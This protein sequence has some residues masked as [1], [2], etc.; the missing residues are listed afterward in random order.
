VHVD[1][2]RGRST[3]VRAGEPA[4][5]RT[6]AIR[7]TCP[8]YYPV[9]TSAGMLY[10]APGDP[11]SAVRYVN[12]GFAEVP[13]DPSLAPVPGCGE[14]FYP[15]PADFHT[16]VMRGWNGPR[17]L[18]EWDAARGR[19]G[20]SIP[21]AQDAHTSSARAAHPDGVIEVGWNESSGMTHSPSDRELRRYYR[22]WRFDGGEVSLLRYESGGWVRT[23][24]A[25]LAV[26]NVAGS[27]HD[28]YSVLIL[29][30]GLHAA[31]LLA[32]SASE[33]AWLQPYRAPCGR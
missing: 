9:R 33:P 6:F 23:D 30:N 24:P 31:L 21:L 16:G 7:S 28:G 18:L 29:R 5:A 1:R 8:V 17:Q 10:V 32:A 13:I 4:S 11:W 2:D 25:P 3:F 27:F 26:S 14:T 15:F 19:F 22:T 12:G 20:A